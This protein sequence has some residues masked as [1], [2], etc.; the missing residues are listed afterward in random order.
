[1]ETNQTKITENGLMQNPKIRSLHQLLTKSTRKWLVAV[2]LI[3]AKLLEQILDRPDFA[4][5]VVHTG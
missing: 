3:G 5:H 4:C 2:D 1:M